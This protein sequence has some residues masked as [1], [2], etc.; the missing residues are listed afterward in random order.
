MPGCYGTVR[1]AAP[2]GFSTY[3]AA[4][5]LARVSV[6]HPGI[7]TELVTSTRPVS[8][9]G[10]GYDL[11]VTVGSGHRASA[12]SRA[13][14]PLRAAA[15]RVSRVS[16][17]ASA[18]PRRSTTS[19]SIALVLLRRCPADRA[20][21]RPARRCSRRARRVRLDERVRADPRPP[22]AERES[23]CCTRSWP[24]AIP[25]SCGCCPEVRV[26]AA[27][28]RSRLVARGLRS[29]AVALVR[30]E[31]EAEVARE[32]ERDARALT[33][34][35]IACSVDQSPMRCRSADGV[36]DIRTCLADAR[37][38]DWAM[39]LRS[40]HILDHW[41]DG[42][43]FAGESTRTLAGLQPRRGHR[44]ARGASRDHR[45]RRHRGRRRPRP[46]SPTGRA[47]RWTKRQG[48]LFTFR[49]LLNARKEEVAAILTNEHGKVTSRRARRD[50]PRPRGR[51]VR[52]AASRTSR[53]AST[54]RTSRP[55]STS[56]RSSQALGVVGIISPFNFPAMVPLWFFPVAIAAGNTVVLKPSEKDPSAAIWMAE[57][58]KEAGL[59][60][61][62]LQ[63]RAR[64]QGVGG[65]PARRTPTSQPSRFVG[66]TPIAKYIYETASKNGKRVQALGGAKNHMLV[67]P[68]RRPR[69]RR[70]LRRQR[71]LRLGRRA[72]HGHLGR[73]RGRAG[74][75]RAHREDHVAHGRP[76]GRRR[77]PRL[78]HGPAHHQGAPR[79]GRRLHRHRDRRRRDGRRRRPR[80]RGRRRRRR[81]LARPD[82]HRQGVRPTSDVYTHEIFGPVLS[83][84]R[85]ET[86]DEG[87]AL[88]NGRQYGNG[89][90]IFTN[91]GGAA[92]RFQREVTG[93]HGRHQRADPRAGRLLLVRRLEGLALRRHEGLR[94]GRRRTSSRARRRSRRAGSTRSTAASTWASRRTGS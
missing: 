81:L 49:E 17:R 36:R 23:A 34:E 74:R 61:G 24:S 12:H 46:R 71:G 2:E 88:I 16:R 70:R 58:L 52:D 87:V 1:I 25:S 19:T 93:R 78:R 76:H 75:R 60:D 54:P 21:A 59:P 86:Y 50:R 31:L 57:L 89:T 82:P 4:P 10:S 65:C 22:A 44:V 8:V 5:A 7:T 33:G 72:L 91:D 84:V 9:R 67:L 20:R 28:R 90:A 48:V 83:V 62:V 92:R 40:G 42:A 56:T 38:A 66:S 14:R 39:T 77:H 85:V 32:P 80:H 53:R 47:R 79:Q 6:A 63:R 35:Q 18:G 64:R 45:R 26:P 15:L 43:A 94:P 55:A 69:P 51:R 27:L 37:I 3:F 68:G 30:A 73:R 41:V 13:A 11:T 29:K